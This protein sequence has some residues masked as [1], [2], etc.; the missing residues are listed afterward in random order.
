[1]G[2]NYRFRLSDSAQ[3]DYLK[4]ILYLKLELMNPQAATNFADEFER[5]VEQIRL[6]SNSGPKVQ[7]ENLEADSIHKIGVK[8]Y[9]LYYLVDDGEKAL[10][11]LRIG[12]E[13]QDREKLLKSV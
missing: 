6:F 10:F 3:K 13:K 12:H 9:L 7:N 2:S 11:V 1:M 8:E 5:K 4:I